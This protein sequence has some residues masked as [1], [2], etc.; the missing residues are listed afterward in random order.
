MNI[1]ILLC[2]NN[3]YQAH[4]HDAGGTCICGA[5]CYRTEKN[6]T[7]YDS[8]YHYYQLRCPICGAYTDGGGTV[9]EEHTLVDGTC[10]CG[11]GSES[12]SSGHSIETIYNNIT[13][14]HHNEVTRCSNCY[15]VFSTYTQQHYAYH[16]DGSCICGTACAHTNAT[17][18]YT[19]I[20]SF[21]LIFLLPFF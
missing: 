7:T 12:C 19:F 18:S 2:N 6:Y 10:I 15:V 20:L 16:L 21:S 8:S 4:Y 13:S 17:K 3:I 14:T 11:Y 5:G 1:I 9:Q